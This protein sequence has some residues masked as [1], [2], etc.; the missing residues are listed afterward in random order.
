MVE[1]FLSI[2]RRISGLKMPQPL[3]KTFEA[4]GQFTRLIT[5]LGVVALLFLQ[6]QFV[7]KGEFATGMERVKKMEEVLIRMEAQAATDIRHDHELED[8]EQR[9]RALTEKIK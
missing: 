8:H 1:I 9:L 7:G 4:I 6:T 2:Q 3:V 5:P